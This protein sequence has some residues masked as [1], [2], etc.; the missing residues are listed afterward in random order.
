MWIACFYILCNLKFCAFNFL[1]IFEFI[2]HYIRKNKTSIVIPWL[3]KWP[4]EVNSSMIS[5]IINIDTKILIAGY[6]NLSKI[7][8]YILHLP[9]HSNAKICY[10]FLSILI[11]QFNYLCQFKDFQ[12][13]KERQHKRKALAKKWN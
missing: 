2:F 11:S 4:R 1:F 7:F 13:P 10:R 12:S 9:F 6:F 8:T 5:I 3:F